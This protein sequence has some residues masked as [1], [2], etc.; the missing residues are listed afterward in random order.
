MPHVCSAMNIKTI[1]TIY[2]LSVA[3]F[4]SIQ[5]N[6]SP[7]TKT[8]CDATV[9]FKNIE[10][11]ELDL[12]ELYQSIRDPKLESDLNKA[13]N[14]AIEFRNKYKGKITKENVVQ[15]M[16]KL[17]EINILISKI[18]AYAAAKYYTNTTDKNNIT[19]F[20][21]INQN[22][23]SISS[24]YLYW[25]YTEVCKIGKDF[26]N[27]AKLKPYHAKYKSLLQNKKYVLGDESELVAHSYNAISSITTAQ[28]N[29]Q[30]AQL[31]QE[32]K[33]QGKTLGQW[34]RMPA[35]QNNCKKFTI[36]LH[37]AALSRKD[38]FELCYNYICAFAHNNKTIRKMPSAQENIHIH[39]YVSD[40]DVEL[41]CK[42]VDKNYSA[43]SQRYFKIKAK[44]LKTKKLRQWQVNQEIAKSKEFKKSISYGDACAIIHKAFGN[45]SKDFAQLFHKAVT[46]G[47]IDSRSN[48]NKYH[49]GW[50]LSLGAGIDPYISVKFNNKIIDVSTLAHEAGHYIHCSLTKNLDPDIGSHMPI[51]IQE[52]SSLFCERLLFEYLYNNAPN[53]EYKIDL[54]CKYIEILLSNTFQAIRVYQFEKECHKL[55]ETKSYLSFEEISGLWQGGS[56]KY[57]GDCVSLNPDYNFGWV[58][59]SHIFNQPFYTYAYGFGALLVN[60]LYSKYLKCK[61]TEE[62]N[63]FVEKYK[64]I[65]SGGG[66]YDFKAIAKEFGL[67]VNESFWQ[68]G[69]DDI[70][71]LLDRLE[72]LIG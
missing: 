39:N 28:Y 61:T 30:I 32:Y 27:I 17:R 53:K 57:Y 40:D 36:C 6:K 58:Y 49:A 56:K 51:V 65:L 16:Y 63:K 21:T 47:H 25:F 62:R 7:D 52:A 5:C 3:G 34:G 23:Q 43:I 46:S 10:P 41:L 37:M 1:L 50:T 54:L 4:Q 71:R 68:A 9:S 29:K 18:S 42:T 66:Q 26:Y 60:V 64:T 45:F 70:A 31:Q 24:L 38:I 15:A 8:Q 44:L 22:M 13:K 72:G 14:M 12:S 19:F 48:L 20:A 11:R 33:Y 67:N 59:C 69:I 55:Y 35:T 2:M